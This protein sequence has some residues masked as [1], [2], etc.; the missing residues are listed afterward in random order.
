MAEA[1]DLAPLLAAGWSHDPSGGRLSKTFRFETFV[2][3]FGFM[4]RVALWAEKWNHHPDWRNSYATVEISLTSHDA[5][6][7]TERDVKLARKIDELAAG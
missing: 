4:T 7:L 2:A 3:A 6:G 5:G 1:L